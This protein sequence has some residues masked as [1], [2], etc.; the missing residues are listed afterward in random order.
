MRTEEYGIK[1]R[2]REKYKFC[3]SNHI[4]YHEEVVGNDK[5]RERICIR[6]GMG[7][8]NWLRKQRNV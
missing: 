7:K 2:E 4:T 3:I 1:E 8:R 5:K 6:Q